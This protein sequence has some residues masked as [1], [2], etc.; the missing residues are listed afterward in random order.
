MTLPGGYVD[1]RM[2]THSIA[3]IA[4]AFAALQSR[5]LPSVA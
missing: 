1:S 3:G 4:I 5:F 2:I